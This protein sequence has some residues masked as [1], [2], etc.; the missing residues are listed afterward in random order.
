M[1]WKHF[2]QGFLKMMHILPVTLIEQSFKNI[3][4]ML[5]QKHNECI[6][7]GMF[8]WNAS[9]GWIIQKKLSP[10]VCKIIEWNVPITKKKHRLKIFNTV[11]NLQR[12][13]RNNIMWT[14][15]K[16]SLLVGYIYMCVPFVLSLQQVPTLKKDIIIRIR[17]MS[18]K[19]VSGRKD[20][21]DVWIVLLC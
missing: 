6:S 2:W 3:L 20:M 11:Y 19:N 14:L 4:T 15:A 5:T 7:R 18:N 8:F 10:K 17:W 13:F 1:P 9:G 16:Q 12:T 21:N